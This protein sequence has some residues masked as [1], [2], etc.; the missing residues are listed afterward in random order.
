MHYSYGTG[1]NNVNSRIGGGIAAI[2]GTAERNC[3][4][5]A[6]RY[7]FGVPGVSKT[8]GEAPLLPLCTPQKHAI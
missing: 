6:T 7:H 8:R 2:H 4:E 1:E 3:L 5:N